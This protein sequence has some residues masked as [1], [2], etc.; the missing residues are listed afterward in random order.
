MP[1]VAFRLTFAKSN[2]FLTPRGG[3]LCGQP[4]VAWAAEGRCLTH[5]HVAG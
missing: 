4:G 3:V 2:P 5:T 1:L